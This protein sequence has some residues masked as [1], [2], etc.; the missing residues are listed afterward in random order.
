MKHGKFFIILSAICVAISIAVGSTIA[1]FTHDQALE[2]VFTAGNV[3]IKL[4][5]ASVKSDAEGNLVQDTESERIFGNALDQEVTVHDYGMIF[6]GQSIYKDPTITNTGSTSAWIAAKVILTDGVG[7]IHNALGYEEDS[8]IDI[9]LLLSGGA[10]DEV[11]T[12]KSWNGINSVQV[13]KDIALIQTA[14]ASEGRYVFYF[15]MEKELATTQS[16]TLFTHFNIHESCTNEMLYEFRDFR[17]S[18]QAMWWSYMNGTLRL[19]MS[20]INW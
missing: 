8:G 5:E 1:Y 14:D 6:P 7:N 16:F 2:S 12:L 4:S 17:I 11:P 19:I 3:Y 10:L 18:V 13:T 15:F 9:R 20:R